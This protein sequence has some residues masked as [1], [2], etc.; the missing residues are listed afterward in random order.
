[1]NRKKN[2]VKAIR[3]EF[4]ENVKRFSIPSA[5]EST[6]VHG[7]VCLTQSLPEPDEQERIESNLSNIIERNFVDNKGVTFE[8]FRTS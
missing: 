4:N 5:R 7:L 6:V 3:L 8:G 1:M 2:E